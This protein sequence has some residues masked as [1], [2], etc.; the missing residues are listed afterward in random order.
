MASAN[1]TQIASVA[2]VTLGTTPNTPRM[3]LRTPTGESLNYSPTFVEPEDLRSDRMTGDSIQTGT[4]NGGGLNY[5]FNYPV[6]NSP[7]DVDIISA[8]YNTWTNSPSRDNDGTADSIITAVATSGTL[9]TVVTG[10]AFVTGQLVRFTGFGVVR[11]ING[12]SCC[13]G[14][15]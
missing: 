15:L 10:A 3:R 11:L 1:R 13:A 6:P 2:E 7:A 4:Q 14:R 12:S 8:L 5:E 9:V